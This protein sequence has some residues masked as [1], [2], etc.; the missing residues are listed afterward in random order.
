[1]E[2]HCVMNCPNYMIE[3]SNCHSFIAHPNREGEEHAVSIEGHDCVKS[4]L[5]RLSESQEDDKNQI[6]KNKDAFI[7]PQKHCLELKVWTNIK[8]GGRISSRCTTK[9][10]I[11]LREEFK[12]SEIYFKCN[13]CENWSVC[14]EC[15]GNAILLQDGGLML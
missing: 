1:M 11:C 5:R 13:E 7:C 6:I 9:C 8:R 4:L 15:M 14:H 3:C 10:N 2:Y 12:L